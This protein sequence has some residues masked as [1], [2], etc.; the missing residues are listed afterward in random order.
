M[1]EAKME[2]PKLLVEAVKAAYELVKDDVTFKIGND[3][4]VL[5]AMDPAN[6][7]MVIVE[8]KKEA[9]SEY[10]LEKEGFV[11]INMDRFMQVLKRS[12]RAEVLSLKIGAGKLEICYTGKSNRRF[13]LPLLALESG[14]RPEPNLSFSA[15]A[16]VDSGL[17]K[18]AVNDASVVS[19]AMT[20]LATKD[21]I[22]LLAQGNLGDVETIMKKGEGIESIEIQETA[23]SKYSTEYLRKI[24][25]AKIGDGVELAFKSEYPLMLKFSEPELKLAFILAPRMDVE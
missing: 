25:K 3:G 1:L 18:D 10:K 14:P 16:V 2:D 7:A 15:K 13:T 5:R 23:R 4:L 17:F 19:D 24:A 12:K 6:V 8:L 20:I 21:E 11:G 9:F 22:R